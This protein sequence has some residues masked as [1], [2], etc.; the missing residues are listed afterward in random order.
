MPDPML[1]INR[2]QG[3]RP[4]VFEAL[5]GSFDQEIAVLVLENVVIIGLPCDFSGEL[6]VPLYQKARD[7]GLHLVV[8]SFNGGYTGYVI[9]D[10]WYDEKRY[11]S[12][13]MSWYGP[14]MGAYHS[15]MI[16]SLLNIIAEKR[17]IR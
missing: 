11:E 3:L 1:R 17:L 10:D 14:H 16:S 2:S 4:W 12:R 15:E 13:T 7:L 9:K 5:A 6:A 8:T